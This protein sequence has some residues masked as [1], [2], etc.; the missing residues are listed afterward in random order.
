[1]SSAKIAIGVPILV[2]AHNMRLILLMYMC[3]SAEVKERVELYIYPPCGPLWP[4]LG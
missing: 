1:M 3:T 2:L 4:V